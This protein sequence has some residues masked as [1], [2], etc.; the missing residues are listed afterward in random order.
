MKTMSVVLLLGGVLLFGVRNSSAQ[1]PPFS[2]CSPAVG[3]TTSCN[4]LITISGTTTNPT[5]TI[6]TDLSQLPIDTLR[7][8]PAAGDDYYI[9]VDNTATCPTAPCPL[10]SATLLGLVINGT[11]T[12]LFDGD[13]MCAG[14]TVYNGTTTGASGPPGCPQ[15]D[16]TGTT[17]FIQID[18]VYRNG[19]NSG[20]VTFTNA[21]SPGLCG[22]TS[23]SSG[24]VTDFSLGGIPLTVTPIFFTPEPSSL[25]LL[26]T[27]LVGWL[28]RRRQFDRI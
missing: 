26:G 19:Q 17:Y 7:N 28:F 27:G 13:G 12:F 4:I 3:S 6:S 21:P 25:F 23:G 22:V 11:N 15:L 14:S 5:V 18:Q 10:G 24:C 20:T 1:A 2:E 16:P 9:G 8:A